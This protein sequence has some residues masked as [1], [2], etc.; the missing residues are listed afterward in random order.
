MFD[1]HIEAYTNLSIKDPTKDVGAGL[2]VI[3]E[4][5]T[6]SEFGE[7]VK[8]FCVFPPQ[9]LCAPNAEE[10]LE[11]MLSNRLK[12]MELE[13]NKNITIHNKKSAVWKRYIRSL[14]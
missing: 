13:G 10:V 4:Y 14:N 7:N 11:F 2:R 12:D 3:I 8:A 6:V 9:T 5:E 1:K